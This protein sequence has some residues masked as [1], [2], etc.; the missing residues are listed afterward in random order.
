ML[1]SCDAAI[2]QIK[3]SSCFALRSSKSTKFPTKHDDS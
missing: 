1:Q 2:M 3:M